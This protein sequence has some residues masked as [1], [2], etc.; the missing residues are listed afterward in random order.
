MSETRTL[1]CASPEPP[2]SSLPDHLTK[3]LAFSS[4][5]KAATRELRKYS[6]ELALKLAEERVRARLDASSESA[7]VERFVKELGSAGSKN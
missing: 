2:M 3:K 7:L 6:A 1:I 5:G 4:A